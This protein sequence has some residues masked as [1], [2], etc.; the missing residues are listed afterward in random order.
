MCRFWFEGSEIEQNC[1]P[2]NSERLIADDIQVSAPTDKLLKPNHADSLVA[3][4]N[5]SI[6]ADDLPLM[7]FNNVQSKTDVAL[8]KPL[9]PNRR[10]R[11][12]LRSEAQSD[13]K[14][15]ARAQHDETKT[16]KHDAEPATKKPRN[17]KT[18]TRLRA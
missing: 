8:A 5:S 15:D 10:P 2:V 1:G 18:K 14:S 9:E 7:P 17:L 16:A 12:V 13:T 3:H 4:S 6:S 11:R